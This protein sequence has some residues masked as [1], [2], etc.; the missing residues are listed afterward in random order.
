[1]ALT[2]L[3]TGMTFGE[4]PRWHENRLYYSDFYRHVVEAVDLEGNVEQ[5]AEVPNQ[6]SGLGW[7]P[8]GRMLIVSM[9]DRKLLRLEADG[10][11]VEHADLSSVAS[12]HCNDMVVDASGR[13]Y[14]GNFGYDIEKKGEEPVLSKL[15]RVDPEGE[16]SVAA[17]ALRFPNGAVITPDGKTMIIAET[18]AR[19]LTAFDIASNGDLSNRRE[20][21]SIHP[22]FPD[23]ICLDSAGGI[24]V[25]DPAQ[26]KVIRVEEGGSITDEIDPGRG[27]FACMLG[28]VD[29]KRLFVCTAETSG[30]KAAEH[31]SARIE[32]HD[33]EFPAAGLP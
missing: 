21:A 27:A 4:G 25:A 16:V 24:W 10:Q 17:E 32:W 19:K 1:M 20:W 3:V 26:S 15:A 7:L 12:W 30:A 28:G 6:P 33:V 11:L 23:G 2:T 22:H 18:F 31:R 8:D 5:I 14:V 29:G 13:A 9:L